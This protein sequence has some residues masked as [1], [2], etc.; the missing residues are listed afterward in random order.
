MTIS[1]GSN[2]FKEL[3][4]ELC[5]VCGH[6]GRCKRSEER[7]DDLVLCF[8]STEEIINGY[9]RLKHTNGCSTY[10]RIG[11]E[12]DR[13]VAFQKTKPTS[14]APIPGLDGL[15]LKYADALTEEAAQ[16]FADEL[17][18]SSDSIRMI[19]AGVRNGRLCVPERDGEGQVIGISVRNPTQKPKYRVGLN[20]KR[21]LIIPANFKDLSD[22]A[23]AVEGPSDVM[24]G[25]TMGLRVIGRPSDLGGA[26]F[27]AV[28]LSGETGVLVVGE[29]DQKEDGI[30]PGRDGAMKLSAKLANSWGRPVRW[31][32][33]PDGYKDIRAYLNSRQFENPVT[34]GRELLA[35]LLSN[36]VEV[37]PDT[38]ID[39]GNSG[40]ISSNSFLS[41]PT[42]K[43]PPPLDDAAY[44]G[45]AGDLVRAIEPNTEADPVALLLCFLAAVGNVIG[46]KVHFV[47]DGVQHFLNLYV[48]LIGETSKGRKG[49]AWARIIRCFT[50][51]AQTWS[52]ER[53]SGGM[54]SGEGL[55]WSVRDP[56]YANENQREGNKKVPLQ[57]LKDPGIEDK[58]LMLIEAEFASVLRQVDRQGNTLSAIIRKAWESGSLRSLTKNSPAQATGAHISIIGDITAEEL[59]RYLDRTEIANGFGN[60]FLWAC[61]RRSKCLPEGGNIDESDLAALT[62]RVAQ[63]LVFAAD[64]IRLER[65]PAAKDLWAKVYPDL[66]EGKPGLSGSLCGRA[67]AQVMRL[68]GIYAA[69]DC[70]RL[71]TVDHLTAAIAV[72]EY[73]EASVRWCFGDALGD[74]IADTILSALREAPKA[75]LTRTEISN[76]LGRNVKAERIVQALA[77]LNTR[78][79]A[80]PVTVTTDGRSAERWLA[81]T[82]ATK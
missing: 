51:I 52:E 14:K 39:S 61:V 32:L 45:V 31:A 30:W 59:L 50:S 53:V 13:T 57:V 38:L 60:R 1:R 81:G 29:N 47:A 18:V 28:F 62:G 35:Y 76:L 16:A 25:V 70:S 74:P 69:L 20:H 77:L 5:P 37:H 27:L 26:D 75:G 34:R 40:L 9:R 33:P 7:G 41:S 71:I 72:W 11:C 58:R 79:L 44:H 49:T 56:I 78:Q 10:I 63:A 22:V 19:G 15:A 12:T 8:R 24:A 23:L 55:I 48:V 4:R 65:D 82:R 67:E 80:M 36:A 43:W 46:R 2:N 21:G 17:G 6:A 64:E 68:A 3:G 42:R 66:S 73:C 54:S